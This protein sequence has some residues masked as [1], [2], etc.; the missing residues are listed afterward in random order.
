MVLEIPDIQVI[1]LPSIQTNRVHMGNLPASG[2]RSLFLELFESGGEQVSADAGQA[3]EEVLVALGAEQEVA[4]E[5]LARPERSGHCVSLSRRAG[6]RAGHLHATAFKISKSG[7][8]PRGS[9]TLR[10]P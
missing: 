1:K 7:D 9:G 3:V 10:C 8:D 2:V 4:D 6:E 5:A